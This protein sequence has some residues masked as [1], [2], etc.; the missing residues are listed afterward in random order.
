MNFVDAARACA[1]GEISFKQ[2]VDE[3]DR[4]WQW[5]AKR[6][7]RSGIPAWLDIEDIRQDLLIEAWR[8][9]GRYDVAKAKGQTPAQWTEF[10]AKSHAKKAV[11]RARGDNRH[12]W[13]W[14]PARFDIPASAF[15]REG[16]DGEL[17]DIFDV[18][19]D[20]DQDRA[21]ERKQMVLKLARE[22]SSLRDFFGVQALAEAEGDVDV[23]AELL[24][25]DLDAR[26]LCRLPS[27]H[28]ARLVVGRLAARIAA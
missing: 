25:G 3:T 17:I 26:L 24:W 6:F 1:S 20:P 2:F 21:V 18:P 12:T 28:A 15:V 11:H 5:W 10:A 8:A 9:L 22:Q 16:E 14:G 19:V 23:A 7:A 13:E 4:R 27:D